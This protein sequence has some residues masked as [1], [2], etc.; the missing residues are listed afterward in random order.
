M[1]FAEAEIA[2]HALMSIKGPYTISSV[3]AALKA[4]KGFNTGQ[5]CQPWTYGA[6]RCTFPTTSTTR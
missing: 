2:V 5:L 3:N 4:V 1:G 6:S